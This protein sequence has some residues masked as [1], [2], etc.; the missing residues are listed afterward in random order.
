MAERLLD[1]PLLHDSAPW[2]GAGRD[3]EWLHWLNHAGAAVRGVQGHLYFNRAEIALQA[4]EAGQGI[5]LGRQALIADRLDSGRLVVAC[6]QRVQSPA[7]YFLQMAPQSNNNDRVIA[8][9]QWLLGL[10]KTG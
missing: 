10:V 9:Q 7:S 3:E 1:Y 6:E 8:L 5:A 2:V 4:A